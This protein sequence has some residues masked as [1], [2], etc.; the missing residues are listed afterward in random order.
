VSPQERKW[1]DG[2]VHQVVE[3]LPDQIREILDE[4]PIIVEDYPSPELQREF[5]LEHRDELCGVFDGIAIT[6]PEYEPAR[7]HSDRVLL[8]REGILSAAA[9]E[10]GEVTEEEVLRQIRI[11]I[12]HEYGH[13]FGLDE[14]DLDEAGYG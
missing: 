7:Q 1:F 5:D 2:L 11:T 9:D 12:M 3:R 13:H 6:Q 10:A 8:F 4:V 14:D